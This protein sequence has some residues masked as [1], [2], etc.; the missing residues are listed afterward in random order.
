MKWINSTDLE[1]WATTRDCQESLPLVIRR[2]I[3]ETVKG[4]ESI[5]FPSGDNIV[6]PGWDGMVKSLEETEYIPKGLSVWEI[7][8]EGKIKQKAEEDYRKRKQNYYD[9][10]PSETVYI[11]LTP[12]RFSAKDKWVSEKRKDKFWKDVRVY[13]ARDLEE[14]LEQAPTVAAWLAKHIGKYT[15]NVLSLEDWWKEWSQVTSP[16]LVPELLL[17]GRK[18]EREK[19]VSWLKST[20]S[21]LAVQSFTKDEVVG[22]LASVI[23]TLSETEKEYFLSKALVV[24]NSDSFRHI[25]TTCK[26]D[27]LLIPEFD[28]IEFTISY[29]NRYHIFI[30]STPDNTMIKDKK[31][32]IILSQMD[33]EEFVYSLDKMGIKREIA[34]KYARD[35]ARII[36]VLRRQLIP[37]P[38][39][40]EWAKY[41]KAKDFLPALLIGKWNESKEGDKDIVCKIAKKPYKEF[42]TALRG[43]L[44]MPDPPILKIGENW[45]LTSRIDAFFALSSFLTRIHFE[46][47]KDITLEVLKEIDPSLDLEPEKRWMASAY[48]KISKNSNDLREGIAETLIL[49]AVFGDK[50]NSG[51]RLDLPYNPQAFVDSIIGELLNNADWKLWCSLSDILP[52]IAEALPISFLDSVESSLAQNPSAIMAMF[53]ETDD[54]LTSKSAYP[55]L[56]WALECLAWSPEL[57]A[58]VTLIL[59]ELAK[60][61]PGGKLDNRPINSLRSIFLLWY[62]QTYASLKQ[63]LECLDLLIANEPEVGWNLLIMLLPTL[64]DSSFSNYKPLWRKFSEKSENEVTIKEHLEGIIYIV[65]KAL[66]NVGNN[67]RRWCDV[68]EHFSSLPLKEREKVLSQLLEHINSISEGRLDLWNKLR[69][70]LSRHRSYRDAGWAL[71]EDELIKI[72]ELYNKLVPAGKERCYQWLFDDYFP[73]IPEGNEMGDYK[74]LEE[75]ITQKRK[76][77]IRSIRDESGIDGIINIATQ[78]KYPELVA[79]TL[80]GFSLSNDEE[81]ILYS[82]LGSEEKSKVYFVQEYIRQK[83]SIN[84]ESY[85]EKILEEAQLENWSSKKLVNLFFAFP[86]NRKVWEILKT[87]ELQIQQKYWQSVYP[88][89][90]DITIEDKLYALEQLIKVRRYFTA[91]NTAAMFKNEIP[92]KFIVELLGKAVLERS[93]DNFNIVSAWDIQELF[94]VLDQSNEIDRNII[95]KFE[96]LYLPI[97]AS[98][99]SSRPPI[100]L[101]QELSENPAFFAEVIKYLYKPKSNDIPEE[102]EELLEELKRQRARLA[103]K[104]LNSWDIVPGSDSNGKIDYEKLKGWVNKA[105]ELCKKMDRLEGC[106]RHIGRVLAHAKSD[107]AGNWPSEEVCKIIED[108]RSKE[109]EIG[110]SIGIYNKRGVVSKTPFE[111]GRQERILAELYKNFADSLANRFTRTS[112][113]IKKVAE[114]Y[115]NEAKREDE[116]AE[117]RNLE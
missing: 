92:P 99:G 21:C 31:G 18:D 16:P 27:L 104:L 58:R 29:S 17:C 64:Y 39:L 19:L 112:A 79:R 60:R 67:G 30:A 69:E 1:N 90:L 32:I 111:G 40:P 13:D 117:K 63:R 51:R 62:P 9:F 53:A 105:R 8:T 59:G 107:K 109:L 66:K 75:I 100:G 83:S 7:S 82:L 35:S 65:D 114:D 97:L 93:I 5:S 34:E 52:L 116:E 36:S 55:S 47:F 103:F 98:V 4:I 95:A 81:K 76:E 2:F 46:K 80:S 41:D 77:A 48:G 22:F 50:V 28:D 94:K 89:L 68:M 86:Q 3:R 42:A 45:R 43:Y 70:I 71:P 33:R 37:I 49:I 72:E 56:L 84:G 91:L 61:D 38:Q 23:L 24:K 102:G 14:W 85:I 88:R 106:D 73:N 25:T 20:P 57:L 108:I 54:I 11:F 115:E 96:W 44:N 113:I 78:A 101:H 110:F 6:Y 15:E 10:N 74:K 26:H 12:R 87:F